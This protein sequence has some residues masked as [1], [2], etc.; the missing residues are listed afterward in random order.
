VCGGIANL[1]MVM[2]A[3]FYIDIFGSDVWD[4][5]RVF[6]FSKKERFIENLEIYELSFFSN[7]R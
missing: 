6:F 4:V 5:D 2:G 7:D 1:L 3:F